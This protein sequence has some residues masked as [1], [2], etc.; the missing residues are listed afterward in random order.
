MAFRVNPNQKPMDKSFQSV[1]RQ[2]M[3]LQVSFWVNLNGK[4]KDKSFLS[5]R[6]QDKSLQ[7]S[8]PIVRGSR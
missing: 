6:R 2:A 5:F 3:S 4:R 8:L 7:V 1:R